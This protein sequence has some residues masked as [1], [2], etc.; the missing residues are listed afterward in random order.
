MGYPNRV[1][2]LSKRPSHL[3][4]CCEER[5]TQQAVAASKGGGGSGRGAR[6]GC[7]ARQ[8]AQL[9]CDG[10]L[11]ILQRGKQLH[12]ALVQPLLLLSAF[13]RALLQEEKT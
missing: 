10:S 2:V 9:V 4:G 3:Q 7:A 8:V 6:A 12:L 11:V 13:L 5:R 1:L